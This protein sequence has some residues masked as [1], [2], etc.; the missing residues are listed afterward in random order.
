MAY[1]LDVLNRFPHVSTSGDAAHSE[2]AN[3]EPHQ[4]TVHVI[5]YI[6]PRQFG[7]H[8][9]FTHNVNR[10]ETVQPFKDYTLREDEINQKFVSAED[11]KIP[12]RLR[13]KVIEL[14]GRLQARH[15]RC[16]YM[17]LLRY[18]CPVGLSIC[19]H[20]PFLIFSLLLRVRD[21]KI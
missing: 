13:G 11:I 14:V 17:E 6:F 1:P 16:P 20:W 15:S 10:Q 21:I 9:V 4:N 3:L 8:N 5:M 18:Y 7:L 12:R 2:Q 19:Q